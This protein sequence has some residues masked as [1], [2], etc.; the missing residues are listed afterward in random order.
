VT[1]SSFAARVI[2]AVRRIPPGR[3]ATYGDIAAL[4]GRPRAARGVGAVMRNCHEAGTPCH[5]VVAAGGRLGGFGGQT[6][7]K[8]ALLVAEGI[9]VVGTRLKNWQAVRWS[10]VLPARRA[11]NRLA[12]GSVSTGQRRPA[13]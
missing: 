7:L 2:S 13:G 12:S 6:V 1:R 11:R 5:R 4:A 10:G 3:A 8:R 9:A